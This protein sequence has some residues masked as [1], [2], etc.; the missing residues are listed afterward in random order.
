MKKNIVEI[1]YTGKNFS[2]HIP[3]LP[4]CVTAGSTPGEIKANIL[5]AIEI[6]LAGMNEDGDSIPESFQNG[7]EIIYNFEKESL[8]QYYLQMFNPAYLS[9][10]SGIDERL[11]GNYAKGIQKP[12][13]TE[14]KKFEKVLNKIGKEL[15]NDFNV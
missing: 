4:G 1:S 7:F 12:T 2:A 9:T 15:M 3:N 6:H 14:L 11:I 13:Q 8:A 5:E 10:L